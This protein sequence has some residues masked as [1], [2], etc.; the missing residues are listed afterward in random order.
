MSKKEGEKIIHVKIS[1]N[2][3]NDVCF[4]LG[5]D[6]EK[7]L[8][9]LQ[10]LLKLPP[11]ELREIERDENIDVGNFITALEN[12]IPPGK[13]FCSTYKNGGKFFEQMERDVKQLKKKLRKS[14]G[15]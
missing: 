13:R 11:D 5:N 3:F 15:L 6:N 10:R 9:T 1:E 12:Q 7:H 4:Q 2:D 14:R 8:Q